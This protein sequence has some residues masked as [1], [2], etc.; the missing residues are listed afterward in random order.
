S[1]KVYYKPLAGGA[2]VDT[3]AFFM[4]SDSTS[5]DTVFLSG[6]GYDA[7]QA[8]IEGFESSVPP[9]GWTLINDGGANGWLKYSSSSLAHSGDYSARIQYNSTAHDDWLITPQ[10]TIDSGDVVSF[11][12]KSG[13]SFYLEQMNVMV[14]TTGNAKTDFTALDVAIMPIT[15]PYT[16][17]TNFSYDLSAYDEDTVYIGFQAISTDKLYLYLDDVLIPIALDSISVPADTTVVS[18]VPAGYT[19]ETFTGATSGEPS[20]W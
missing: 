1:F 6:T 7:T 12:S 8:H 11:W 20:G 2:H 10:M 4:N 5:G 16:A 13:S 17:W 9:N 14:S 19:L 15:A 3:L 18:T